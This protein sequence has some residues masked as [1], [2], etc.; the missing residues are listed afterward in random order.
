MGGQEETDNPLIYLYSNA[1]FNENKESIY[2]YL[3]FC[4]DSFLNYLYYNNSL[5]L[6]PVIIGFFLELVNPYQT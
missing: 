6:L 5:V 3:N 2:T 1:D 4:I